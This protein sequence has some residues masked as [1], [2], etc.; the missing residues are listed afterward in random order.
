MWRSRLPTCIDRKMIRDLY[1]KLLWV[2]GSLPV[3]IQTS[4][5]SFQSPASWSP[6]EWWSWRARSRPWQT[7]SRTCL[8]RLLDFWEQKSWGS[9]TGGSNQ[10]P[11]LQWVLSSTLERSCQCKNLSAEDHRC[12]LASPWGW[13]QACRPSKRKTAKSWSSREAFAS[14]RSCSCQTR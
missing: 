12:T 14:C 8:E 6:T 4:A 11:G 9:D 5:K 7:C 1:S 2:L 3:Q 10:E 13:Q